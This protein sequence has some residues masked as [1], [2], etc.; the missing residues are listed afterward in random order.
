M[1][2]LEKYIKEH[3]TEFDDHT[4]DRSIWLS[5]ESEMSR[6]EKHKIITI[7][8]WMAAAVA[9]FVMCCGVLIGLNIKKS[10]TQLDYA[11]NSDFQQLKDTE[12]YYQTQVNLKLN[13]IKDPESKTN[14]VND[15]KQLDEIYAQLKAEIIRSGYANSDI[16]I[17]AMIKNQKTKT[18]IL[19]NILN[20]QNQIKNEDL[21]L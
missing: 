8:P 7:K 4:P 18:E 11:R 2:Q 19:E 13:E 20:K 1:N 14:V 10:H 12:T 9:V 5:I 3:K 17:Q 15:L 21:T 6:S 16:I